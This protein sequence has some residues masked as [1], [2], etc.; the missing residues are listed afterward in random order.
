VVHF[1][2]LKKTG[3]FE[4]DLVL[5][6]NTSGWKQGWFYLDNPMLALPDRT[7]RA[8]VPFPLWTNQLTTRETEEFRPLLDDLERSKAEGLT[9]G[10]VA[11]S[12]GCRLIQPIQDQVHPA[13]EYSG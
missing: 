11:I 5:P 6:D 10:A 9:G 2:D 12:F 1:F 8:L 13:F 7:G 4:V 3:K